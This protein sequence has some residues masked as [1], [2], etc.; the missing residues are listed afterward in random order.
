MH[1]YHDRFGE[2]PNQL[3]KKQDLENLITTRDELFE[4]LGIDNDFL[5]EELLRFVCSFGETT[6]KRRV[7]LFHWCF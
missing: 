7:C 2:Y 1:E 3:E 6:N 4:K 5:S